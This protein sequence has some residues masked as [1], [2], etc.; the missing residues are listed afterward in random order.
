MIFI[1]GYYSLAD[2]TPQLSLSIKINQSNSVMMICYN[3]RDKNIDKVQHG[4]RIRLK[5]SHGTYLWRRVET[6]Y[7][8]HQSPHCFCLSLVNC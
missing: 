3:T 1:L 5:T 8:R 7:H 4:Q 2:Q 6:A